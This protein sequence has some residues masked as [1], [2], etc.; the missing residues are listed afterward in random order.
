MRAKHL[1]P[2]EL[3]AL[4]R[5][6]ETEADVRHHLKDCAPCRETARE[7][8]FATRY[9]RPLASDHPDEHVLT[10]L[11]SN[12][13]SSARK[14]QVVGHVATCSRCGVLLERLVRAT[15]PET[16]PSEVDLRQL[17]ETRAWAAA[18]TVPRQATLVVEKGNQLLSLHA[19]F[20]SIAESLRP[21]ELKRPSRFWTFKRKAPDARALTDG[22]QTFRF[23]A[24]REEATVCLA[25]AYVRAAPLPGVTAIRVTLASVGG[26]S[27][28]AEVRPGVEASFELSPGTS[29]L[30]IATWPR[31]EIEIRFDA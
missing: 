31:W 16:S 13:L 28:Q 17:A 26:P 6:E 23:K 29:R 15:P 20:R 30:V 21:V 4:V 3:E 9:I 24:Y 8:M 1:T 18:S 7:G 5:G 10:A 19:S 12:A 25:V 2:D 22:E 27:Q 11:W 14:A